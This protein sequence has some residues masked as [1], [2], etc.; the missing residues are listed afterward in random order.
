MQKYA[1]KLKFPLSFL[2]SALTHHRLLTVAL[3]SRSV[4][5]E[6]TIKLAIVPTAAPGKLKKVIP[7]I[8]NT[9]EVTEPTIMAQLA[10]KADFLQF[11]KNSAYNIGIKHPPT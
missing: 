9:T 2:L 4:T 6:N 3:G 1:S 5:K 8:S 11:L 7:V 10:A